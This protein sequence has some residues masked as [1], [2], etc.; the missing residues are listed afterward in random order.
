MSVYIGK[1][2]FYISGMDNNLSAKQYTKQPKIPEKKKSS[3]IK[4]IRTISRKKMVPILL[5]FVLL[6]TVYPSDPWLCCVL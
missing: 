1:S 3:D 2:T 6:F 5:A 4:F